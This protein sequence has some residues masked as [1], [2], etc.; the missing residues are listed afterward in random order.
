MTSPD[1]IEERTFDLE[2]REQYDHDAAADKA[3]EARDFSEACRSGSALADLIFET[4]KLNMASYEAARQAGY[5]QGRHDGFM[6][7][8]RQA[9]DM[10]KAS[11]A[12]EQ[13]TLL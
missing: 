3:D 10:L 12:A 8:M 13:E 6:E 5:E 1:G 4:A 9:N 11:M 7:G 2:S